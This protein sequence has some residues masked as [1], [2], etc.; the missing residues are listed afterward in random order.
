MNEIEVFVGPP[1]MIKQKV[2]TWKWQNP[3]ASIVSVD[4]V[5]GSGGRDH[6]V[7]IT[8]TKTPPVVE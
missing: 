1:I 5:R 8:Y 6:M 7:I 2:D 3:D 4:T